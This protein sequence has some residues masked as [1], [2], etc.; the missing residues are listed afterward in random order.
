MYRN[1]RGQLKTKFTN[2][3]RIAGPGVLYD[4]YDDESI[5]D[6]HI[7]QGRPIGISE[8]EERAKREREE[9]PVTTYYIEKAPGDAGTSDT[10]AVEKIQ[11]QDSTDQEKNQGGC[12]E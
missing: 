8:R 7:R 3:G 1:P 6:S 5:L 10:G 12:Y 4:R 11:V 2:S 9:S